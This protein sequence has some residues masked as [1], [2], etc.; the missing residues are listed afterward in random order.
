MKAAALPGF[1]PGALV[2]VGQLLADHGV[3]TDSWDQ[4]V[5][6]LLAKAASA[7]ARKAAKAGV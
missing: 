1:G 6:A 7:A 5:Q 2:Q 3:S 4:A